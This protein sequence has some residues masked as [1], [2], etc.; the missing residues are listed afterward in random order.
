MP[1][2]RLHRNDQILTSTKNWNTGSH[3]A[4]LTGRRS[5]RSSQ[6]VDLAAVV[7]RVR[8]QIHAG[9]NIE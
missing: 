5:A 9:R 1:N 3:S 8:V 6:K 2:F 4:G 7:D